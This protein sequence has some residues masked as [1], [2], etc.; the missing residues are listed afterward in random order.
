[1]PHPI[2]APANDVSLKGKTMTDATPAS[3][4]VEGELQ[5]CYCYGGECYHELIWEDYG[6]K[7][8]SWGLT[9]RGHWRARCGVI[10]SATF[11]CFYRVS[12]SKLPAHLRPCR[13]CF[14]PK[15]K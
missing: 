2:D 13:R 9:E 15:D 5:F 1:M 3:L 8:L 14:S 11:N 6:R 10:D 7:R 4:L 12:V